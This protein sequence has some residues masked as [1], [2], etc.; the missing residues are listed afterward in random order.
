MIKAASIGCLLFAGICAATYLPSLLAGDRETRQ[1][2]APAAE[3]DTQQIMMSCEI[4]VTDATGTPEIVAAPTI[5][6]L[7]GQAATI[8][9]TQDDG[10]SIKIQLIGQIM[11]SE[12]PLDQGVTNE[13]R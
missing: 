2:S 5:L 1:D 10:K 3:A 13:S 7:D 8:E 12:G 6:A 9:M 11:A 4:T